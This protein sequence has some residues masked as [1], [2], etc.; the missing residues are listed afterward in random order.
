MSVRSDLLTQ[1]LLP[2]HSR[3]RFAT[4]EADYKIPFLVV[5]QQWLKAKSVRSKGPLLGFQREYD[6]DFGGYVLS[7]DEVSAQ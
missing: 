7:D 3:Q 1:K 6:E 4:L 2:D 5:L